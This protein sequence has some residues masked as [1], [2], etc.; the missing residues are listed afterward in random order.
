V[1]VA[2]FPLCIKEKGTT[3]YAVLRRIGVLRFFKNMG[4]SK[5]RPQG[6]RIVG[7]LITPVKHEGYIWQLFEIL[8][9]MILWVL[10]WKP[11][12]F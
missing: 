4:W 10:Y 6:V 8:E 5:T 11:N 2:K 3:T 7:D 12:I 1:T 9:D